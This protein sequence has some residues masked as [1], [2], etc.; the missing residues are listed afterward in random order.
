VP[1]IAV[2]LGFAAC[3]VIR[4]LALTYG[5]SVYRRGKEGR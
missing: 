4:A 1:A 2:A 5:W 3:V